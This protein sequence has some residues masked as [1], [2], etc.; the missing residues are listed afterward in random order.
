MNIRCPRCGLP[1]CGLTNYGQDIHCSSC[2]FVGKNPL[3]PE[4]TLEK[5]DK[6]KVGF[7]CKA[8]N[9]LFCAHCGNEI[10]LLGVPSI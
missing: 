5:C 3:A 8:G 10:F 4:L 2:R 6:C 9:I 7:L 1:N